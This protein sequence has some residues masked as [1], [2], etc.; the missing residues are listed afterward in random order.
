MVDDGREDGG[1]ARCVEDDAR[2]DEPPAEH[3][4]ALVAASRLR[5][6]SPA[7][8]PVSPAQWDVNSAD[9]VPRA[10]QCAGISRGVEAEAFEQ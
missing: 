3:V 7:G 9:N 10:R 8:R 2:V 1:C 6:G 4:G 5:S